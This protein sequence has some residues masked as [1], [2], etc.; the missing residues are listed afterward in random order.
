MS[1]VNYKTKFTLMMIVF[2]IPYLI[3]ATQLAISSIEDGKF[4]EKE[5][6]GFE[7]IGVVQPI[8]QKLQKSRGLSF[9]YLS[10][11]TSALA[12]FDENKKELETSIAKLKEVD[13]KYKEDFQTD[14]KVAEITN[15]WSTLSSS[16]TSLTTDETKKKHTEIISKLLYLDRQIANIS[17]M[18]L[19]WE[20]DTNM[21]L[22][23]NTKNFLELSEKMGIIR[24][25]VSA[26]VIDGKLTGNE[27]I[28]IENL[29]KD[30]SAQQNE[31]TFDISF[32]L[33]S[34]SELKEELGSSFSQIND[35]LNHIK[36]T[37]EDEVLK[38]E[39]ITMNA[40]KFFE[41]ATKTIDQL[42]STMD[43]N[44][45]VINNNFNS[46]LADEYKT[47]F[48]TIT[49][50]ILSNL[51]E[52]YLFFSLY[53][54][55][56]NTIKRLVKSLRKVQEGD[57][58]ER[59]HLHVKDETLEI[60]E[61][62][63]AMTFEFKNIV[64][65]TI[66]AAD[67]V[68]ASAEEMTASMQGAADSTDTIVNLMRDTTRGIEEQL[69]VVEES[70]ISSEDMS[71]KLQIVAGNSTIVSEK[72]KE[73]YAEATK[74]HSLVKESI[75]Q[76]IT[77][78]EQVSSAAKLIEQL[79]VRSGEISQMTELI[80]AIAEQTNLLALNAAI[81]AARA[82]EHGKGFAVVADEVRKLAEQTKNSTDQIT[83]LTTEIQ[84][85][86]QATVHSMNEGL[87]QTEKGQILI[88]RTG[89]ALQ[90][91]VTAVEKV[92]EEILNV[93]SSTEKMAEGSKEIATSIQ[94]L[95]GVAHLTEH[96]TEDVNLATNNQLVVIDDMN[97]MSNELANV[98]TEMQTAI[99]RFK[100]R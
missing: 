56:M 30:L 88:E 45:E 96:Y 54:N 63:N 3:A 16:M 75:E 71:S 99:S 85:D 64:E 66:F 21:L 47:Q 53:F 90:A 33:N 27:R 18:T 58:T 4:I 34:S 13:E 74:G 91:I 95:A 36:M 94:Q 44:K 52:V 68:V 8:I 15:T 81:E 2:M 11:D 22:N 17:G 9:V 65:Q 31:T 82:G 24:A 59:V 41:D 28:T 77:I 48:I 93:S 46:R 29:L 100:V 40:S 50:V 72:S 14:G 38:P 67:H 78:N 19:D 92:N 62:V 25:T 23:L 6:K 39:K 51:L 70:V 32:V 86:T 69:K 12:K 10:G 80:T 37:I 83:K 57:L 60:E 26:Y 55:L 87:K 89:E 73:T 84:K 35:L 98:A 49:L 79:S 43:K 76:M 7:Y 5:T 97:G 20:L 61:V 1:R 42:Y